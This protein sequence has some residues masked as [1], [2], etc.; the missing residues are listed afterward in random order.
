M[1]Q[2]VGGI[3]AVTLLGLL[4]G[5]A[6]KSKEPD[7]RAFLAT[8]CAWICASIL[9]GF[10]M[11]DG[12]PFRIDAALIYLPGAAGAFFYLRWHYGKMWNADEED[13]PQEGSER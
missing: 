1:G 10:G 13:I 9:A 12:G 7:P 5:L 11:A 6:L 8:V 2:L 4:F 3:L